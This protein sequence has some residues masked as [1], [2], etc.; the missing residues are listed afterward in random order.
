MHCN[1]V[2][3][4]GTVYACSND[5]CGRIIKIEHRKPSQVKLAC[6]GTGRCD[7]LTP[8]VEARAREIARRSP[9]NRQPRE[10]PGT[11]LAKI[12][13][14][15]GGSEGNCDCASLEWKM[16]QLGVEDCR[17]QADAL[18]ERI[19]KSVKKR[20]LPD[21]VAAPEVLRPLFEEALRR[22]ESIE[23]QKS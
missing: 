22:A 16:N 10:G 17:A 2:K 19:A 14:E 3:V 23:H 21:E 18:L 1:L 7:T 4:A 8:E 6:G 12:F 11:E 5:G 13:A 20:G 9:L 15:L